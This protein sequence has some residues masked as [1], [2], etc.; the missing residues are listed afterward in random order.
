L[1]GLCT[2]TNERGV[3][4]GAKELLAVIGSH[5][6]AESERARYVAKRGLI[7]VAV[8]IVLKFVAAVPKNLA[9]F[10]EVLAALDDP[11]APTL[12]GAIF[13]DELCEAPR[14]LGV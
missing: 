6:N 4:G 2:P 9:L 11:H 10:V 12:R 14:N 13:S 3:V 1:G 8:A 5:A 7:A